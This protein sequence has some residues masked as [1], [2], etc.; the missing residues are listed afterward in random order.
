MNSQEDYLPTENL[1]AVP[2]P[3]Q[4][5]EKKKGSMSLL[6]VDLAR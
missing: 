5:K 6:H 2:W 4:Q 1:D 3:S